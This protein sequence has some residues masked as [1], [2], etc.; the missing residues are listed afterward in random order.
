[1]TAAEQMAAACKSVIMGLALLKRRLTLDQALA[2]ARLEEDY[3]IAEW[4]L[5]E[6]GHDVDI[7]DLRVRLAAP[8]IFVRLLDDPVM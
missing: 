4:G 2:V 1:L 6:G 8:H 5:V 7:A 3:Q